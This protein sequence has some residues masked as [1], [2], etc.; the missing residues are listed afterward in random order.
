MLSPCCALVVLIS[1]PEPITSTRF[2]ARF[3]RLSSA[4]AQVTAA[5]QPQPLPPA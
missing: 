2:L 5:T 1:A 4:T 3:S